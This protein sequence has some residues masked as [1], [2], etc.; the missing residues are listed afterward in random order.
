[1]SFDSANRASSENQRQRRSRVMVRASSLDPPEEN[2]VAKGTAPHLNVEGHYVV[3]H[4]VK[5]I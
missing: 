4:S 1:M 3:Q 5:T 2:S